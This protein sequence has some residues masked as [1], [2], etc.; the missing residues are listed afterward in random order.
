MHPLHGCRA[1][2]ERAR[3]HVAEFGDGVRAFTERAPFKLR[4]QF[5]EATNELVITA[6]EDPEFGPVP[7]DLTLLAGE[8]AHQLRSALDHL[9]WQLVIVNTGNLPPGT[10]SQFPIFKT[11][12]GYN[13]RAAAMIAGVSANAETRIRAAQPFHAGADAEQVLTW[14]VH[15]LN[16]TDKHRVIAV[17]TT[18]SFVGAVRMIKA[19][20]SQVDVV[21]WREEVPEPLHDGM[22]IAR[23]PIA[24]GVVGATFHVP[25][26]LDVAFEQIG[27]L[28]RYP[29]TQLLNRSANYVSDLVESFAGEFQ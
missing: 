21:P 25:V 9:V 28:T 17:T 14:L 10:K 20:G 15:E 19:D 13:N 23:V 26:G 3:R 6:E 22:E 16:N 7:I 12:A 4:N 1:K 24:D 5:N 2:I 27:S 18:Y 8:V 29:A 11:E